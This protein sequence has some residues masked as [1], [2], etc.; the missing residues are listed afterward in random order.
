MKSRV[1]H[2]AGPL[3]K[4]HIEIAKVLGLLQQLSRRPPPP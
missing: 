3:H 4:P 2:K 1:P